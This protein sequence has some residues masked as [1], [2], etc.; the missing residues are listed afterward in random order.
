MQNYD[1][2]NFFHQAGKY[3]LETGTKVDVISDAMYKK[4][5]GEPLTATEQG[6]MDDIL[7]RSNYKDNEVAQMLYGI[8]RNLE[9]EY[10]L[11]EGSLLAA[12]NKS[13]FHCSPKENE[14]LNAYEKRIES[15][16]HALY[17]GVSQSRAME[18]SADGRRF[19]GLGNEELKKAEGESYVTNAIR[20]GEGLNEGSIPTITEKYGLFANDLR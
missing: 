11:K 6:I 3:A 19:A 9:V 10:G 7:Q 1:S 2:Q 4:A 16:V 8:R 5:N 13:T 18:L 14:A 15:E 17:D 20:T 12:V